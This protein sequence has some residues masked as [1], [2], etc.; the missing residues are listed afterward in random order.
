MRLYNY[1]DILQA[2]VYEILDNIEGVKIY[3]D[4]ILILGRGNLSQH[5][6]QLRVI[7]YS[8]CAAVIRANDYK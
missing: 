4:G 3:I 6:D 7:F 1:G 5:I 8:L 2:E